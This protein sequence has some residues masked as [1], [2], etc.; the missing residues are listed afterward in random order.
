MGNWFKWKL[1]F[2]HNANFWDWMRDTYSRDELRRLID[3]ATDSSLIR[4]SNPFS[5][6]PAPS[7][8]IMRETVSKLMSQYGNEIWG[9]CLGAGGQGAEDGPAGLVCLARLD[10]A[11]QV[12]DP[13]TFEEFLVRN[14]LKHGAMTILSKE[15]K[16][17]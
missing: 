7:E 10:R 11:V 3:E 8:S 16:N 13:A 4:E 17:L 14:A 15:G 1:S 12:Y 2:H 6:E 9:I 5:H